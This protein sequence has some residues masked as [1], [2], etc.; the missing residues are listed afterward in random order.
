MV[1]SKSIIKKKQNGINLSADEIEFMV[2]DYTVGSIS[3]DFMTLWLTAVFE[4]GMDYEETLNYTKSMLSSGLELNFS[5]SEPRF[6]I[7]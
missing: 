2:N 5:S 6:N 7:N 4:N 1:S 3:D